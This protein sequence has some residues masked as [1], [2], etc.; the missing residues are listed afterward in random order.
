MEDCFPVFANSFYILMRKY[1]AFIKTIIKLRAKAN[2][3][4]EILR[5]RKNYE[6][7]IPHEKYI[8]IIVFSAALPRIL[9]QSTATNIR[10]SFI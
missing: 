5:R 4:Q 3:L 2:I 7:N 6:S 1:S 8:R 9:N 10:S